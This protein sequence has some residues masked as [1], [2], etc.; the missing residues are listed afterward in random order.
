MKN[1]L[2]MNKDTL[3]GT[4]KDKIWMTNKSE[5]SLNLFPEEK[6]NN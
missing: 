3:D 5:L 2:P 4:Y 1:T 6:S